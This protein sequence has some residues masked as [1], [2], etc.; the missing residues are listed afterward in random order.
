MEMQDAWD[1]LDDAAL[2][3]IAELR[4]RLARAETAVDQLAAEAF[5]DQPHPGT[6]GEAWRELWEAARRFVGAGGGDFPDDERGRDL[7]ALPAGPRRRGA[8]AAAPLRGLRLRRAARAGAAG[9]PG[10]DRAARKRCPTCSKSSTRPRWRWP[11]P[12]RSC[13][14]PPMPRSRPWPIGSAIATGRSEPHPGRSLELDPLRDYVAV[15]VA[16][17]EG[18]AVLRNEAERARI[19]ARLRALRGRLEIAASL[20]EVLEHLEAL[21]QIADL[22]SGAEKAL[23][24]GDLPPHPRAQQTGDHRPPEAGAGPGD[25]G[26][27]PDRRPGRAQRLGQQGQAGSPA[28]SSAARDASESPTS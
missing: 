25:R 18:F 26:A 21:E 10:S 8:R 9:R 6:G 13:R 12:A 17:A 7:S 1:R 22:G 4:V 20:D 16:E 5:A 3:E 15:Q 27:R 24:P 2:R 19:K 28:S 23:D 14:S 11:R